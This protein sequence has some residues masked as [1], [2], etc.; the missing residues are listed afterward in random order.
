MGTAD[1]SIHAGAVAPYALRYTVTSD[2]VAPFDL[3]TVTAVSF[4]I[5]R[6][7][8]EKLDTWSAAIEN[9]TSKSLDVVHVFTTGDVDDPG[10]IKIEPQ[11]STPGGLLVAAA[12][13]L[14][15][16]EPFS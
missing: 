7:E 4:K 1:T 11:L 16:L 3:N 12:R 2:G 15:V 5:R 9:K 6:E 13:T 10:L 14:K 8:S